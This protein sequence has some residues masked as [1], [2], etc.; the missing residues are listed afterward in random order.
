MLEEANGFLGR[1]TLFAHTLGRQAAH[2]GAAGVRQGSQDGRGSYGCEKGRKNRG[3][4]PQ[5]DA[6]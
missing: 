5:E 1:L 6:K 4:P 2:T 3:R